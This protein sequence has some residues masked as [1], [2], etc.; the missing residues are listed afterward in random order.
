MG[1]KRLIKKYEQLAPELLSLIKETYPDGFEDNLISIPMPTGE[2]ALALPL[3]TDEVSY[4]IKLPNN[5]IP[6]DNDDDDNGISED[7][8]NFES[9]DAAEDIPDED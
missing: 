4:L 3:E 1:K 6:E 8:G 2:L 5:T 9:L 7:F